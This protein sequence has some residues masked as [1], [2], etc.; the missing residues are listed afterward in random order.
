MTPLHFMA[1]ITAHRR[2]SQQRSK[3]TY[4]P[5]QFPSMQRVL[6]E[7]EGK[8]NLHSSKWRETTY[9][10]TDTER[11]SANN[12]AGIWVGKAK[13]SGLRNITNYCYLV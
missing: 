10:L 12:M 11:K 13:S 3:A 2:L 8:L 9:P 6:T 4:K 7:L 5:Q 1:C